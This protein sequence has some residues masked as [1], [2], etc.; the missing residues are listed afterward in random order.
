MQS[1]FF[2]VSSSLSVRIMTVWDDFRFPPTT[3]ST[4]PHTCTANSTLPHATPPTAPQFSLIYPFYLTSLP[5][6]ATAAPAPC[7][8]LTLPPTAPL[9]HNLTPALLTAYPI[10][11]LFIPFAQLNSHCRQ[12]L[13]LSPLLLKISL[14]YS[15]SFPLF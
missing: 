15:P 9:P 4:S 14:R 11:S 12:Q 13:P 8:T 5:I 3:A 7:P 10:Q 2:W 6:T 1:A